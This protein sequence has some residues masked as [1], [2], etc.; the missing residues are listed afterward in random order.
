MLQVYKGCRRGRGGLTT[1][2][3]LLHDFDPAVVGE[4]MQR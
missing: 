1:F 2:C 4:Y 3:M